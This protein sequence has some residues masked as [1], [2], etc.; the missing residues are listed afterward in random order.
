MPI[1]AAVDNLRLKLLPSVLD[2][3]GVVAGRLPL[4]AVGSGLSVTSGVTDRTVRVSKGSCGVCVDDPSE[5]IPDLVPPAE[6]HG[7]PAIDFDD[8]RGADVEA[9]PADDD[10]DI[11]ADES[12]HLA[13]DGTLACVM[14]ALPDADMVDDASTV[15]KAS[16]L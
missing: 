3:P 6:T 10:S 1:K 5:A 11:V 2:R 7:S 16:T 12:D 15:S 9:S 8:V 13:D 14:I 4:L